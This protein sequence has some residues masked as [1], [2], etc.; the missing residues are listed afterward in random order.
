MKNN[1]NGF[2]LIEI[3]IAI[4]V[5]GLLTVVG[6]NIYRVDQKTNQNNSD[7]EKAQTAE[8]NSVTKSD[9]NND[10][11]TPGETPVSNLPNVPKASPAPQPV[12]TPAPAKIGSAYIMYRIASGGASAQVTP[13]TTTLTGFTSV[14]L[15][16]DVQCLGGCN[17]KL[18][19]DTI[20]LSNVATYTSSQKVTYTLSSPGEYILY[21]Q[22][23]PST[24]FGIKF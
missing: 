10:A 23:T 7:I 22:F 13:V 5:V 8:T 17:F 21:N 6:W 12:A 3:A 18:I 15:T 2:T 24:K 4:L 14:E 11:T 1:E 16:V 19:S 9:E 20:T